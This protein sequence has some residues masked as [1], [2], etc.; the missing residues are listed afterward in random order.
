MG[1]RQD[2]TYTQIKLAHGQQCNDKHINDFLLFF[3]ETWHRSFSACNTFECVQISVF[4]YIFVIVDRSKAKTW[5]CLR[6][7]HLTSRILSKR[8]ET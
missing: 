2:Q 7:K 3:P 4:C 1:K 8:D 6:G 5:K